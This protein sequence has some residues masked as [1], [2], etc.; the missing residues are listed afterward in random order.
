MILALLLLPWGSWVNE[1]S[2]RLR[3]FLQTTARVSAGVFI[4]S[5]A[6]A[7]RS[8]CTGCGA[9]ALMEHDFV[10]LR[11]AVMPR[12]DWF[13]CKAAAWGS[14]WG[15]RWRPDVLQRW[16][17][18]RLRAPACPPR[19][20]PPSRAEAAGERPPEFAGKEGPVSFI[21]REGLDRVNR[22]PS[23]AAFYKI[24]ATRKRD[25]LTAQLS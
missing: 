15:L 19:S 3:E 22:G 20:S 18:G 9:P 23:G 24:L 2:G 11:K 8:E 14:V 1:D 10:W 4:C 5:P 16:G 17:L 7:W 6:P 25:F 12:D 13:G 21:P